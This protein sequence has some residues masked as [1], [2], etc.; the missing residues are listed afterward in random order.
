MA[1]GVHT[2]TIKWNFILDVQI[3]VDANVESGRAIREL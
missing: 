3:Y 2:P 1:H